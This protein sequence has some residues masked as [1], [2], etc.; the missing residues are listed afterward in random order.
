MRHR[1]RFVGH[2]SST[3]KKVSSLTPIQSMAVSVVDP[4][5]TATIFLLN[6]IISFH[7]SCVRL[8]YV[9]C[10]H[11]Q[12]VSRPELFWLDAL[13]ALQSVSFGA[14]GLASRFALSL[15]DHGF[16]DGMS[17]DEARDLMEACFRQ[18]DR[19]YLVSSV[20]FSMKVVDKNGCRDIACKGQDKGNGHRSSGE[21]NE[22]LGSRVR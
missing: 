4:S 16:R 15:L 20:G 7:A 11:I 14:H 12:G 10:L 5:R 3:I 9:S 1:Q 22:A 2:S 19:R 13:G 17:V 6:A 8:R 21:R 18:L